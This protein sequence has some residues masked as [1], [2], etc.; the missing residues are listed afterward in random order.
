MVCLKPFDLNNFSLK[1]TKYLMCPNSSFCVKIRNQASPEN[2][3]SC[4]CSTSLPGALHNMVVV[5]Q[6]I[7][8]N[9]LRIVTL[10]LYSNKIN[11]LNSEQ[12]FY[13]IQLKTC[14]ELNE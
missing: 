14:S 6:I 3:T 9:P 7:D 11:S 4:I 2:L 1:L 13:S 8:K 12:V 5:N 10:L